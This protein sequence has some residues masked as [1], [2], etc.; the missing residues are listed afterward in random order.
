MKREEQ[1]QKT[2]RKIMDSALAEF[3]V[4]GYGAASI[5]T[6]CASQE[7]SKGIIYHYFETRDALY[8]ACVEE[9]FQRL[10]E[11]IKANFSLADTPLEEQLK[12]YFTLRTRFFETYPVYQ[13]IF[14]E[15]V[16]SPP[17]QLNTEIQRCKRDFDTLNAQIL[18]RLLSSVSLR[19]DLSRQ[20]I[21][22]TLREFQNFINIC[23]QVTDL[24]EH[25]FEEREEKCLKALSIFLYGVIDRKEQ[26]HAK[27]V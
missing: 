20:D 18:Q 22:E 8:L 27:T 10:T 15:V 2:R 25:P 9:C 5:N 12:S 7:I 26:E 19:S 14:C 16:I 21:M 4:Q 1:T 13:G 3:S 24:G 23:Y 11:Y 17:S 6:I